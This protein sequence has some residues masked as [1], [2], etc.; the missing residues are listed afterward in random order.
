MQ[1]NNNNKKFFLKLSKAGMKTLLK[2]RKSRTNPR[3]FQALLFVLAWSENGTRALG[4]TYTYGRSKGRLCYSKELKNKMCGYM[5]IRHK[6]AVRYLNKLKELNW[7][8]ATD[9]Q[10]NL[11]GDLEYRISPSAYLMAKEGEKYFIFNMRGKGRKGFDIYSKLESAFKRDLHPAER[12]SDQLCFNIPARTRRWRRKRHVFIKRQEV[13]PNAGT[14]PHLNVKTTLA[15]DFNFKNYISLK[16]T[17]GDRLKIP[18]HE[19]KRL[20]EFQKIRAG[21]CTF[22][23]AVWHKGK[24]FKW[25]KWSSEYQF[26]PKKKRQKVTHTSHKPLKSLNIFFRI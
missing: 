10:F 26:V 1:N 11:S 6:Q 9:D 19:L 17:H 2:S 21:L 3:L 4:I 23:R 12:N 24:V 22:D 5:G 14:S 13:T 18:W 25:D 8:L 16:L 20:S 15:R 7:I